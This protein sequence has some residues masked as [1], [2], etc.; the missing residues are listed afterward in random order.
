MLDYAVTR[1]HGP[2]CHYT[3]ECNRTYQ[4]DDYNIIPEEPGMTMQEA[5]DKGCLFSI[6]APDSRRYDPVIANNPT[7]AILQVIDQA[8][9]GL[10]A[11]DGYACYLPN[12]KWQVQK[13][14]LAISPRHADLVSF[15]GEFTYNWQ[16]PLIHGSGVIA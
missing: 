7:D 11:L 15:I 9:Y 2:W 10:G 13:R 4:E 1:D 12:T 3:C 8:Q 14:T 16:L 5:S 6:I